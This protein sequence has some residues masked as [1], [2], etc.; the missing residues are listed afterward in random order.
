MYILGAEMNKFI[1]LLLI[2]ITTNSF[3]EDSKFIS[4]VSFVGMSMD[5]TEYDRDGSILDT[6]ES[7]YLDLAGVEISFG[8]NTFESDSSSSEITFNF[9][10]LGGMTKYIG[11]LQSSNEG[12]GSHISS[13]LNTVVDTD[14]SYKRSNVFN[15]SVEINYGIGIGYREWN[16]ALSNSQIEGYTWY[17]IRPMLGISTFNKEKLNFGMFIEYQYGIETMMSASDLN[18]DFTL[19]GADIL[20]VS[21]PVSYKYNDNIGFFFEATLQKQTIKESNRLYTGT[22]AEYYYEPKS[23]AYNNYLEIG[24]EYNF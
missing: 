3:G 16:R 12:Y 4:A 9:M 11:S 6:E 1:F 22:G 17:S 13:T 21:F 15:N 7:S 19:G 24:I 20:E 23:T 18:Y 10:I 5:Y 14:I 2:L 8:Y